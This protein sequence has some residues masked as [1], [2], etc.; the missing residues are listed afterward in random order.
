MMKKIIIMK[1]HFK[2]KKAKRLKK[3]GKLIL[4]IN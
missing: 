3:V 2:L 4:K 1:I